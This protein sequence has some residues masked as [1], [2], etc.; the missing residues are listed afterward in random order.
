M[1]ICLIPARSGSKRIK[2]KNIK[3]F[4][5]KP[6]I[7]Y[8]IE[9]AVK[10]KL[11]DNIIVSTDSSK[12]Q[13]IA[14]RYG[15]ETPFLRPKKLS[16]DFASDVDVINHYLRFAK[17]SGIKVQQLCYLY[18]C[19][20]LIKVMTLK[21]CFNLMIK[22]NAKRVIT[23]SK[24]LHPIQRVLKRNN[25]QEYTFKDDK[26]FNTRSQDLKEYYQDAAQC[27]WYNFKKIKKLEKNN[28]I[29]SL[30]V[31]LKKHEYHDLDTSEDL[32]FLKKLFLINKKKR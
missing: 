13:R 26:F 15:A 9:A 21:K 17:Q 1:K 4:F 12:I 3:F 10:S 14:K 7:S 23:V 19:S 30:A 11:F 20:P 27:Y 32:M 8:S 16:N 6:L 2:N 31:V 18:P 24:L 29:K 5:G 28:F 22:K 25:R